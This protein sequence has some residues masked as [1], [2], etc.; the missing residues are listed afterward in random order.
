MEKV[1]IENSKKLEFKFYTDHSMRWINDQDT[2][3]VYWA[4]SPKEDHY[5]L[6][7]YQPL[8]NK[9]LHGEPA[10]LEIH[11]LRRKKLVIQMSYQGV[12]ALET[13]FLVIFKRT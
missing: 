11:K 1:L 10:V 6:R 8:G 9:K 3:Q 4:L 5:D 13:P 12:E 7:V 2:A